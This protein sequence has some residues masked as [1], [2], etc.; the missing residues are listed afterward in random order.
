[1]RATIEVCNESDAIQLN[2]VIANRFAGRK[3][4]HQKAASIE[5]A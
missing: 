3:P 5:T 2:S 1:M 4:G